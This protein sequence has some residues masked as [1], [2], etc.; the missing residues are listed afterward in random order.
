[1]ASKFSDTL[2]QT[3][4]QFCENYKKF[5]IPP[6]QRAYAWSN[7]QI[8]DLWEGI[9]SNDNEYFI[10]N[11]VCL[12]A[13]EDT[14]GRLQIIDG[15]QRLFTI[16]LFLLAVKNEYG[17]IKF[18]GKAEK[19]RI[20]KSKKVIHRFLFFEQFT[21]PFKEELRFLPGKSNLKEIY[22]ELLVGGIDVDSEDD[23]KDLDDN[24]IKYVKNYKTIRKLVQHYI[25]ENN[26][27]KLD[28]LLEKITAL[29]FI[30]IICKS[31]NDAYNIFEGLNATGI[32]LSVAD[33]VKNAV[34]H[35][36]KGIPAKGAVE[37][38][39][40]QIESIFE[41]T[42]VSN[43]PKYLRHQWISREGYV[44]NSKLFGAIKS[45]KLHKKNNEEIIVYTKELLED[46][47]AY[48]G[49]LY[50][51]ME[52]NLFSSKKVDDEVVRQI[53]KFRYLDIEQVYEVILA[54]YNKLIHTKAYT[55]KQFCKDLR[56]LW[57][58][59]FRA[60]VISVNPSEYEKKFAEHCQTIKEFSKKE[61]DRMSVT[62]YADLK[63][64]VD[65]DSVF[66]ENFASDIKYKYG[67]GNRLIRYLLETIMRQDNPSIKIS[68]PTIEHIIPL[69][70]EKW[71]LSKKDVNDFVNDVGNL[72]LL[73][74]T[75]NGTLQNEI[76][77]V[78]IKKVYSKSPF[79]MNRKLCGLQKDFEQNPKET[80]R[81]RGLE[82]ANL[83]SKVFK[84]ES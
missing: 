10:G 6:F 36:V 17:A 82:L 26:F 57:I 70:P 83:A 61:M 3:F 77:D 75:D 68:E 54:Y 5:L 84:M 44:N 76:I 72:T 79:E 55:N 71:G 21:H 8:N 66:I 39:W 64:L 12:E 22:G 32:G 29:L 11:L 40:E 7:K 42:K 69:E 18:K 38:N 65:K 4:S 45:S 74:D 15:Q 9:I 16:T 24:Q 34:L 67:A 73:H 63:K 2:P 53:E 48:S 27:E 51:Q 28:D 20:E 59:A 25:K 80:V 49:F 14:E 41:A 31:D 13:S 1:M 33:L 78:K 47:K 50:K 35:A 81:I 23:L 30:V 46:A 19:E 52:N 58:F 62:F 43:F 60:R 56:N 37:D